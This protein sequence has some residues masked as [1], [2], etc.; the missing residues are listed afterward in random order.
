MPTSKAAIVFIWAGNIPKPENITVCN[1]T[2]KPTK[3]AF[4]KTA[5]SSVA[6]QSNSLLWSGLYLM[7]FS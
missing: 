3:F 7:N 1:A 6:F 5:A 2:A 4:R